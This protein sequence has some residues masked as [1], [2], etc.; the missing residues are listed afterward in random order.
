VSSVDLDLGSVIGLCRAYEPLLRSG[1]YF[2][3]STAAALHGIP[4]PRPL[5][6]LPLHLS[7]VGFGAKPRRAHVVGHVLPAIQVSQVLGFPAIAPAATWFHL[8]TQ[9]SATDLI[10]AG[11]CLVSGVRMRGG[12]RSPA[13]CTLAQLVSITAVNVGNRGAAKARWAVAR[14]R[15]GVDSPRESMLRLVLVDGGLP[16]PVVGLAVAVDSGRLILH[17]DLALPFWRVVLEYEGDEHRTNR[18]RFQR[19]IQRRELFE[20]ANWRVIRVTA[21]DLDAARTDF[22]DRVHAILTLRERERASVGPTWNG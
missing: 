16:E 13:Q 10:A 22:L 14:I 7:A 8:A 11:D 2:S 17:P 9:L 1:Q 3:H 19:D 15:S 12:K 4:L 5:G 6:L 18:K 21:T 20:A